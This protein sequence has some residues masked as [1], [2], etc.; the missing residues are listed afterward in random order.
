MS[1]PE[2]SLHVSLCLDASLYARHIAG[3]PN[4]IHLPSQHVRAASLITT[5][6]VYFDVLSVAIAVAL[7]SFQ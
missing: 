7:D 6:G 1:A 5:V 4:G 3:A 2:K